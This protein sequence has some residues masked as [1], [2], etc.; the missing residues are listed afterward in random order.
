MMAKNQKGFTLIEAVIAIAI[1]G[2]MCISFLS[3]FTS[4]FTTISKSGNRSS[5]LF[6]VQSN[7]EE[8]LNGAS[9]T[10]LTL[11]PLEFI[12]TIPNYPSTIAIPGDIITESISVKGQTVT[13]TAFK[14]KPSN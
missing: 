11:T 10:P 5:A 4:G 3:I 8:K 1:I 12:I 2:I 6:I 13:I 14:P 9:I 7:I